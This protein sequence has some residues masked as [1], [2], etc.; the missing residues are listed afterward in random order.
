MNLILYTT[1]VAVLSTGLLHVEGVIKPNTDFNPDSCS[2]YCA[3]S[4]D[5]SVSNHLTPQGKV[6]YD[7]NQMADGDIRTAWI[8]SNGLGEWFEFTFTAEGFHPDI[9]LDNQRTGVDSLYIMNGYDKSSQHWR[10]HARIHKLEMSIDG[11]PVAVITL[12][13]DHRPQHVALPPTLL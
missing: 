3:A 6:Q 5:L 8:A 10:D 13:D 1:L 12:K 2:L 4:P 11:K 9:P 7:A